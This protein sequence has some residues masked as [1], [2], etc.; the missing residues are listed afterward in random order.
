MD[1]G[2]I[3]KAILF[4]N[5]AAERNAITSSGWFTLGSAYQEQ[6]DLLMAIDAWKKALPLARADSFL[7]AAERS[8]GNFSE[9]IIYW[10]ADIALEPENGSS[11]Y[12]LGLL[13]AATAPEQANPELIKA[14]DLC[15]ALDEPVQSL[16]T[17]LNTAFL[18]DDRGYQFL[19]SG[20]ALG[21]LGEWDLA[22]EAFRNATIAALQLWRS[23]GLAGRGKAAT[24]T[25]WQ[26]RN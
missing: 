6:G 3:D 25:G 21:A 22:A 4:L 9:A 16:R 8:Q 1:S 7:A 13:L 5:K 2:N 18:S 23:M 10:R 14:A 11:H 20:Q 15:S 12:T 17:A 19:V 26:F 24:G